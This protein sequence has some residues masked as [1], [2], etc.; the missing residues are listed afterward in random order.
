[1]VR[2]TGPSGPRARAVSPSGRPGRRPCRG[3]GTAWS[4]C[5]CGPRTPSGRPGHAPGPGACRQWRQSTARPASRE[6]ARAARPSVR[7]ATWSLP[8]LAAE[9]PGGVGRDVTPPVTGPGVETTVAHRATAPARPSRAPPVGLE[10]TTRCLE[11]SR[12]IQLSYGGKNRHHAT[13]V[14]V[15][16]TRPRPGSPG[17]F[18]RIQVAAGAAASARLARPVVAVAQVVR[19]SGCGPEGRGFESP[20]S[21]Q[22]GAPGS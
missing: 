15:V 16:T 10:P 4:R 17:R 19:A 2:G 7:R 3:R 21:P 11:G 12:S 14:P 1:M 18:V 5:R 6:A 13:G 9:R 8:L 22:V 20:R